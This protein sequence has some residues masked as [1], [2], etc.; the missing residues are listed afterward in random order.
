MDDSY[1]RIAARRGDERGSCEAAGAA[2][3]GAAFLVPVSARGTSVGSDAATDAGAAW[4]PCL[5]GS[6]CVR[7]VDSSHLAHHG[8]TPTYCIHVAS[9]MAARG[10]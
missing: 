7:A 1:K 5:T 10:I 9:V 2:N 6:L 8:L 4:L 3:K